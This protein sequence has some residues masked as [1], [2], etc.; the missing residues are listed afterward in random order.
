MSVRIFIGAAIQQGD[1]TCFQKLTGESRAVG[2]LAVAG[3]VGSLIHHSFS[4]IIIG[5]Y[6]VL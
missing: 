6:E 2:G 1:V 4:S 5:V 3:G